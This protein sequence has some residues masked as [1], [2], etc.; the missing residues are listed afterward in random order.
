MLYESDIIR[1]VCRFLKSQ[2][3][4]IIQQLTENQKGDDIIAV[5]PDGSKKIYIEAKGETSSKKSTAR[6]GK[7]F[8]RSQVQD[9]VANAFF[10]AAQR[11]RSDN[12]PSIRSGVALPKTRH[13]IDMVKQIELAIKILQIEIFWVTSEGILELAGNW[14]NI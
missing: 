13:H 3:Y 14:E 1:V 5:L 9:H 10:K 8:D 7:P 12:N 4:E 11:L 6:F 2:G